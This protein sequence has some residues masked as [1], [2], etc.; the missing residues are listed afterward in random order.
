MFDADKDDCMPAESRDGLWEALGRPER[1]SLKYKHEKSFLA[2]TPLGFFWMR[3][4]VYDFLADKLR[5]D[6]APQRSALIAS[7]T[8]PPNENVNTEAYPD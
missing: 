6:E 7:E 5:I 4:K 2:M 3:E 1:Y 8:H